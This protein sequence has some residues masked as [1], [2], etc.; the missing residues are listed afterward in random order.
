M[1]SDFRQM[2][3]V[4]VSFIKTK[5]GLEILKNGKLEILKLI[6][7]TMYNPFTEA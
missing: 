2:S 5:F 6:W 4:C 7:Q 3:E 1:D